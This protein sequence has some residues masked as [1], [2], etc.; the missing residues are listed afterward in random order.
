M[1]F[2]NRLQVWVY[3]KV[4]SFRAS[5]E[6]VLI[7]VATSDFHKQNI[8]CQKDAVSALKDLNLNRQ[9]CNKQ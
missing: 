8:K 9:I 6:L 7:K 4:I 5:K 3:M 1:V 2:A